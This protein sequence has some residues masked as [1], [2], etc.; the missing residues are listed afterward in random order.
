MPSSSGGTNRAGQNNISNKHKNQHVKNITGPGYQVVGKNGKP[1]K[2]TSCPVTPSFQQIMDN[3]PTLDISSS[4]F[5]YSSLFTQTAITSGSTAIDV[6]VN[7]NERPNE[8]DTGS[9]SSSLNNTSIQSTFLTNSDIS[10]TNK[11]LNILQKSLSPDYIGPITILVE[12]IDAN[13]NL[14]NWHSMKA[15][16][17]FSNNFPGI[18]NIKPAGSK[19]IKISF[20]TIINGNFYLNS[21]I[22]N[23]NN[24]NAIIPSTL[25]FS[26]GIIKLDTTVSEAEFFEGGRSSVKI[27]AFKR[28]SIK[29]DDK[30]IQ[31]RIVE[32][33]FVASK[34]PSII[35]V[36]NM[37]L[38]STDPVPSSPTLDSS[39]SIYLPFNFNKA[40]WSSYSLKIQNSI[41]SLTN[42]TSPVFSYSTF[43]NI[44]N[45][46]ADSTIP[47]KRLNSNPYPPSPLGGIPKPSKTKANFLETFVAQ[48][49]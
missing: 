31:T 16:K 3:P 24:Y 43:T 32:L 28:I 4:A 1:I 25:I 21:N 49:P 34:I 5:N 20:D 46:S 48:A 30:I 2:V 7:V 44:I 39:S 41:S 26:Y 15:A 42:S 6:D 9:T 11:H 36:F 27:D 17:F 37:I 47:K 38:M 40:N 10:N 22:L 14:G 35:S 29:K 12:S 13:N 33:K 18:T 45:I 23:K 8:L 19:K